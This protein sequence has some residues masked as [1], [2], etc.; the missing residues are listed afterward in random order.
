MK[1]FERRYIDNPIGR[2][3]QYYIFGKKVYTKLIG[4]YRYE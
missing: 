1:I 4:L 3:V 2:W